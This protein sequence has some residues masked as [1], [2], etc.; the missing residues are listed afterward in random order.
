LSATIVQIS[1]S[2]RG[3]P[4]LPIAEA[5][6][7]S[8]GLTGDDHRPGIHGG[9]DRALCLFAAER[10]EALA[11][12]GHPIAP[13]STGENITT[14]GLDWD[15]VFPGARLRLGSEVIIEITSYTTPCKTIR[16]CFAGGAFNRIHHSRHPGWSRTYARVLQ[17]GLIHRGT[18]ITLVE[19]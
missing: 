10:I 15:Q 6:V 3:V 5:R 17:Q 12:E 13:G 19:S 9:P 16:H 2:R 14:R 7:T 4:K 11:A 1:V 18:P 8:R